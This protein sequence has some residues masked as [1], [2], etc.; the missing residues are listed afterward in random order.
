M[1]EQSP[2]GNGERPAVPQ[3]VWHRARNIRHGETESLW[4]TR[5]TKMSLQSGTVVPA[6]LL[7]HR[8]VV[9]VEV[10]LPV[11]EGPLGTTYGTCVIGRN[12]DVTGESDLWLIQ[13][14]NGERDF[15]NKIL[16]Q[17]LNVG[18]E[19]AHQI[20]V[21]LTHQNVHDAIEFV[22]STLGDAS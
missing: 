15:F 5:L 4:G 2:N 9:T 11:G 3:P 6:N 12:P 8:E 10:Q 1:S 21:T 17:E 20:D 16:W 14:P 22:G 18:A 13:L 19:G 7:R